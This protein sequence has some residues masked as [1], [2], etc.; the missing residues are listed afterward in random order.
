MAC[1]IPEHRTFV[2]ARSNLNVTN[3]AGPIVPDILGPYAVQASGSSSFTKRISPTARAVITT[4]IC[5]VIR[6]TC[7]Q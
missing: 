7:R 5:P 2:P 4:T 1:T 3:A 6:P